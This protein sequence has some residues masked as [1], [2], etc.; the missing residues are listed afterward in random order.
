LNIKLTKDALITPSGS[1]NSSLVSVGGYNQ[2]V[3]RRWRAAEPT[4]VQE[5]LAPQTP[6]SSDGEGY[7]SDEDHRIYSPRLQR[8][9]CEADMAEKAWSD[10]S[11]TVTEKSEEVPDEPT[12][13]IELPEAESGRASDYERELI[14]TDDVQLESKSRKKRQK[15]ATKKAKIAVEQEKEK[16]EEDQEKDAPTKKFE[17]IRPTAVPKFTAEKKLAKVPAKPVAQ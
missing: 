2:P 5:D 10:A 7:S 9:Y 17:I 8:E 12:L 1:E 3:N 14:S 4:L 13:Y 6:P 15:K 11:H 16:V